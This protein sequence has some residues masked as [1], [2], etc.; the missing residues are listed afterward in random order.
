MATGLAV[1]TSLIPVRWLGWTS[2]LA[3]VVRVPVQPLAQAGVQVSH[4]LRPAA[5]IAGESEALR[6]RTDQLE[7]TRA[8][9][10]GA[11]LRIDSLLEEIA[12]MQGV[13]SLRPGVEITPIVARV[14]ARSPDRAGGPVRINAGSRHGVVAGA[15]VVYRG[16]HLFGVV[17]DGVSRLSSAVIPITDGSTGLIEGVV[18]PGDDTVAEVRNRPHIQFAS[19]GDGLLAGDLDRAVVIKPGD[20]VRLADYSWLDSAQGLVIGIVKSV[21]PKDVNP[22][23]NTVTVEPMYGPRQVTSVTVIIER[24]T[25]PAGVGP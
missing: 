5:D 9:L 17:A 4:W 25:E 21:E 19:D 15:I 11:R 10:H 18:L 16:G 23:L 22:L 14:T 8:L 12:M 1:V 6:E 20:I 2:G 24:L 3:T 7:T 13:R